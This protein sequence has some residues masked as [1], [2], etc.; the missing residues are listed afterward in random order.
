M[1]STSPEQLRCVVE[2]GEMLPPEIGA[3]EICS[4]IRLAS[5]PVLS[6]A[7]ISPA[8][9]SV[10]VKVRSAS[11]ISATASFGGRQLRERNVA[12]SNRPL[13][14]RAVDMLAKA[15]AEELSTVA[16]Q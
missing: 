4:A 1:T 11:A 16:Q 5:E 3:D 9:V 8:A 13:T 2:G 10:S 6:S 7:A 14:A 15:V 12:T